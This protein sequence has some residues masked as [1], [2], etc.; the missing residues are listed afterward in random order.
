MWLEGKSA[1]RASASPSSA[2][3]TKSALDHTEAYGWSPTASGSPKK[4]AGSIA[5]GPTGGSLCLGSAIPRPACSSW[6]WRQPPMAETG[7]AGSLPAIG[8]G[9]GSTKRCMSS[10]SR[11]NP[12]RRTR[13]MDSGYRIVTSR[14]WCAAHHRGT[15]DHYLKACRVTKIKGSDPNI[16]LGPQYIPSKP[17]YI[18]RPTCSALLLGWILSLAREGEETDEQ[19]SERNPLTAAFPPMGARS[20][21]GSQ[22]ESIADRGGSIT[23]L[24]PHFSASRAEPGH[25]LKVLVMCDAVQT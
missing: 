5:T 8:A 16:F 7:P 18:H 4:S 21:D 17:H 10:G 1:K 3:L 19:V 25:P 2:Y 6:A 12:P 24:P 22:L 15:S 11:I 20:I 14:R 9:T 13:A 23:F